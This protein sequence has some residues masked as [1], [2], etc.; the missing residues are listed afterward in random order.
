ML[1]VT[2]RPILNHGG[3]LER[4]QANLRMYKSEALEWLSSVGA[5]SSAYWIQWRPA[6]ATAL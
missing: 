2:L 5:D 6:E 4:Y 3:Q 1:I